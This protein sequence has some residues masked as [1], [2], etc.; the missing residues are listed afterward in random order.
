MSTSHSWIREFFEENKPWRVDYDGVRRIRGNEEDIHRRG[1]KTSKGRQIQ[2][3]WEK[4]TNS[5]LC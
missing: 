3:V 1:N 5:S 4:K 2:T